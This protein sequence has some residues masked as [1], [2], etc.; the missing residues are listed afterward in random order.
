[1]QK[2]NVKHGTVK[3]SVHT[4]EDKITG[5]AAVKKFTN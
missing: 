1:M 4:V 5:E 2:D 3:A